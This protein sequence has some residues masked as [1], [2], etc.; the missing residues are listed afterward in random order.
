MTGNFSG[1]KSSPSPLAQRCLDGFE[2]FGDLHVAGFEGDGMAL[3]A[4]FLG[5]VRLADLEQRFDEGE[6]GG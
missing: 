6:V 4:D 1:S 5:A 3:L 2:F